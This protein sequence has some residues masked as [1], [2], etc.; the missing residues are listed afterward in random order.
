MSAPPRTNMDLVE[1]GYNYRPAP[2][3]VAKTIF[4]WGDP[5][6]TPDIPIPKDWSLTHKKTKSD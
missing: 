2:W 4:Y 3:K 1:A 6:V 5:S